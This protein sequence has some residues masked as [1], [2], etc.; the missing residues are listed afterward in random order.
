MLSL[1]PLPTGHAFTG[2]WDEAGL[3]LRRASVEWA[4]YAA[5]HALALLKWLVNKVIAVI[6]IGSVSL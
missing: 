3:E 1:P 6:S 2:S 4:S 5:D